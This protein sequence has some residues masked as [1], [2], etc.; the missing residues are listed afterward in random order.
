[1]VASHAST[2]K[3]GRRVHCRGCARQAT[4]PAPAEGHPYGWYTLSVNVPPEIA[5][6]GRAYIYIGLFCSIGC[7]VGHERTLTEDA[8]LTAGLYERELSQ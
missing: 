3:Y 1:M 6:G 2:E 4:T 5:G 7:L 8:E